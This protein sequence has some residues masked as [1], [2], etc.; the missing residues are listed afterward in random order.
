MAQTENTDTDNAGTENGQ[1]GSG[2]D[3]PARKTSPNKTSANKS[4][5][6]KTATRKSAAKKS[7]PRKASARAASSP[8]R[9]TG[10]KAAGEAARQLHELTGKEPEGV[11]G[12]ERS[13][14]GWTVQVEVLELRRIPNTTDVL[15]VYEVSVDRDGD[16]EGYTRLRRYVRGTPEER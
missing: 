3:G 12:L 8:K 11:V 16:L 7:A 9:M 15:A 10:M 6:K 1:S 14:D 13:D 5:A 4:S 2:S